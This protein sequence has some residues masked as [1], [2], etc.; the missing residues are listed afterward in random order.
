MF[1][2][3]VAYAQITDWAADTSST[4]CMVDGVPTFKCIEYV[5][6]NIF[7]VAAGFVVLALFIML[8]VG[9]FTYLTSFGNPEKVKKA[10]GTLK[11]AV[12]GFTL[13]ISSFVIL[14]TIDFLFLGN[15]GRI[16]KFEIQSG[17]NG[18]P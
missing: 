16:F 12:I 6:Q 7:F 5:F 10:Q 18:C 15:C 8:L 3:P 17:S 1:P 11:F 9:G 4:G 14:K 2:I 13:Y